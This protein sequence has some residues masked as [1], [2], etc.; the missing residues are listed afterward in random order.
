MNISKSKYL[1]FVLFIGFVFVNGFSQNIIQRDT[2]ILDKYP[3]IFSVALRTSQNKLLKNGA[4]KFDSELYKDSLSQQFFKLNIQGNYK[5]DRYH[6]YWA[7]SELVYVLQIENIVHNKKHQ[8]DYK[9]NGTESR[10][11]MRFTNGQA[12]GRWMIDNYTI[13]NGVQKDLQNSGFIFCE[14]G[15]FTG[16]FSYS[17]EKENISISGNL[18]NQG[19]LHGVLKIKW[20]DSEKGEISEERLYQDGFL[21]QIS[22]FENEDTK[23]FMLIEFA[24]VQ[25]LLND[26]QNNRINQNSRI[27]MSDKHYGILFDNGYTEQDLRL[28]A[29]KFG[30]DIISSF[31]E[32]FQRFINVESQAFEKPIAKLT[33][34]FIYQYNDP[35]PWEPIEMKIDDLLTKTKEFINAPS[36]ILYAEQSDSVARAWTIMNHILEKTLILEDVVQKHKTD[37]FDTRDRNNYYASGVTGLNKKEVLY[38]RNRKNENISIDF[39]PPTLVDTPENFMDQIDA[40]LR[41]LLMKFEKN[42]LI[43]FNQVTDLEQRENL[44]TIDSLIVHFE[45]LNENFYGE[46]SELSNT[47]FENLSFEQKIFFLA[48]QRKLSQL[49]K[50]YLNKIEY[51]E[52]TDLGRQYID[53]MQN[54]SDN[55]KRLA[56]I[57][58]RQKRIDSLFTI[59]ED[60]PFDYRK[61]ELPILSQIKEKGLLLFRHYAELLFAETRSDK[62]I[63]RLAAI[64][65]LLDKLE[66]YA[67]NYNKQEVQ[68]LNRALRRES[69]PNRIERLFEIR[70]DNDNE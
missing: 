50:N 11:V 58:R 68:A 1:L 67:A 23:P 34:R 26:L 55:Q 18:N 25:Q 56:D 38:F 3:G 4:A 36:N 63:Q 52:K 2:L 9:L 47:P 37:F 49:R 6:G 13:M 28:H 59:Y 12:T 5:D 62:F 24:D 48:H 66:Y 64:E 70:I 61:I 10:V 33:R 29:Q 40:Y 19:F 21:L 15:V 31:F 60:N 54:L 51:T 22:R 46:I 30:N 44:K 41:F 16:A 43:A 35:S 42:Q 57:G 14:N 45:Q 32:S 8:L 65:Q 27:Q 39:S 53:A 7:F 69:V 17:N 20:L